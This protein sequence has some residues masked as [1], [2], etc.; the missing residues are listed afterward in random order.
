MARCTNCWRNEF[1]GEL[2]YSKME[3]FGKKATD[4]ITGFTGVITAKAIYM[5]GGVK[6]LLTPKVDEKGKIQNEEWF[7]DGRIEVLKPGET[8]IV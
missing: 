2:K 6:Y 7:D 4:K 8:L 1:V 3:K 5:H